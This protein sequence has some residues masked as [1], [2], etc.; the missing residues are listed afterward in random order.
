MC[1]CVRVCACALVCVRVCVCVLCVCAVCVLCVCCVWVRAIPGGHLEVQ[2]GEVAALEQPE[3]R[4]G[5]GV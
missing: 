2:Q 5:F 3:A 1:R 4:R